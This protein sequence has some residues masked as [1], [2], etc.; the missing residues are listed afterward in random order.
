MIDTFVKVLEKGIELVNV[1]QESNKQYF[2]LIV[3]PL[4][5]EFEKVVGG[6]LKL[7]SMQGVSKDEALSIR[8]G[9]LQSRIKVTELASK[10]AKESNDEELVEY[11]NSLS[12]FFYGEFSVPEPVNRS[13]G[14]YY[15]DILTGERSFS[16][17]SEKPNSLQHMRDSLEERWQKV[18]NIYGSLKIKYGTPIGYKA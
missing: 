8:E 12:E 6:Y 7:F 14:R 16:D 18:V 15:I 1:R 13:D 5:D 2:E 17:F 10:F 11:F 4:F 3:S 9:Y